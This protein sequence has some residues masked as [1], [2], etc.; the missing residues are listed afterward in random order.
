MKTYRA[1]NRVQITR[2]S[3]YTVIPNGWEDFFVDLY[4]ALE[5]SDEIDEEVIRALRWFTTGVAS[6]HHTDRFLA[7]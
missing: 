2:Q 7:F 5:E 1:D 3:G 4:E 6:E